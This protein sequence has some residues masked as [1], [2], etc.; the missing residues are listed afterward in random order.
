MEPDTSWPEDREEDALEEI[1]REDRYN[2]E[3]NRHLRAVADWIAEA[4]AK[5]DG[6]ERI[7][8]VGSVAE[9]PTMTV[10]YARRLRRFG[11]EVTRQCSD[12]D[13][14]V[15]LSDLT[16]LK[17][18]QRARNLTVGDFYRATNYGIPQHMVDTFIVEPGTGRY[19]GRLCIFNDCPKPGKP[20]CWVP[21]CGEVPHLK[22]HAGFTLRPEVLSPENSVV[23][24]ERH[25]PAEP[26]AD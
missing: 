4:M 25:E 11:V 3:R 18:L 2:Q 9:P 24:F 6:V 26:S 17:A 8:L 19:L 1:A 15:A 12:L 20:E 22:Q 7:L 10:P 23:L 16:S 13:L 14:A 21:S 5:V